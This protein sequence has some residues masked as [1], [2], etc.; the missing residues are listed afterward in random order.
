MSAQGAESVA[1]EVL[2]PADVMCARLVEL[3]AVI[4][5]GM[6][7]FVEVGVAL[8]EIKDGRLYRERGFERFADYC[9]D[10]WGLSAAY[11]NQKIQGAKVV[12]QLEMT[13]A[14]VMPSCEAQTREL[15]P[16]LK[17]APGQIPRVWVAVL[18]EGTPSAPKIREKVRAV[19][20]NGDHAAE[21]AT[22]AESNGRNVRKPIAVR[23]QEIEALAV[24]G[25]ST[26]QIAR[27]LGLG[28]QRV[29]DIVAECG[30]VIPGDLVT[31]KTRRLDANRVMEQTVIEI[32]ESAET[33]IGLLQGRWSDLDPERVEDWRVSLEAAVRSVNRLIKELSHVAVTV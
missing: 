21:D 19:M 4:E 18:E 30:L 24:N 12:Q 3:E 13:A 10:H 27:Q 28:E 25:S 23:A 7:S 22:P 8:M 29:R 31:N 14:A 26:P 20:A 9:Q 17:A 2:P 11:A 5:R 15:A 32:R 1:V 33:T 16:L 6:K